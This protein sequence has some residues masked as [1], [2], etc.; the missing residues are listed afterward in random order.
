MKISSLLY[1]ALLSLASNLAHAT[2]QLS[3]PNPSGTDTTTYFAMSGF[4]GEATFS[5]G[6]LKAAAAGTVTYTYLGSDAGYTNNFLI[7]GL[8]AFTNKETA[9]GSTDTV[10]VAANTALNFSFLTTSVNPTYT[11][12]NGSLPTYTAQNL[13]GTYTYG[14]DQGV[15]GIVK[16]ATV[17][18]ITYQALL[19][20]NDPVNGGDHDYNDMVVGVNFT[21]DSS[22]QNIA[23][24]VP[25]PETYGMM[26]MGLGLMGF[27]ARRRRN[28]QA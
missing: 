2:S 13:V 11:V 8:T 22:N 3:V 4:S 15:F 12:S 26:L 27:V 18:E 28:N 10:S 21:A 1:V 19:I 7:N 6:T 9:V 20:Y 24:A 14:Q 5:Y 23:P 17:H 16:G 25:E